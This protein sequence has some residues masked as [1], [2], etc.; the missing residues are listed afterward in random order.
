MPPSM[1]GANQLAAD[2]TRLSLE[3]TLMAWIRTAGSLI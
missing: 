2:R 1:P 3:R